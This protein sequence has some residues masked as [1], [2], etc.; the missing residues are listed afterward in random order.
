MSEG[1]TEKPASERGSVARERERLLE[2]E[3]ATR[4]EA[5]KARQETRAILESISDGFFALDRER[6]FVYVNREAERFWG[7]PRE[8]LLGKDIRRVFPQAVGTE[9]YR[10]IDRAAK[11]GVATEFEAAS[12]V[13]PGAWVGGRAYPSAEG[14]SVYFRDVSERKRAEEAL[15]ESEEFVRQLLRNFPN[16]S[17]N[18]FDRDLRYLL[19]EGRGLEEE[20]L[21]PEMLVGKTLEE[22]FPKESAD[23]VRPYYERA[24]AGEDVEFELP[25]GDRVYSIHAAPLRE[26]G[27]EVRTIIAV[28][29][30]V[31]GRKRAEDELRESRE[32]LG[33]SEEFHRFA[34]EAGRIGTWD[35]DLRTEECLISPKMADLMGFSPDQTTVPGAQWREAIVPDDRTSMASALAASIESGAPFDLE[36]RIALKDGTERW[37]YSR[38]GATRDASGKA[39]R[40]HGASIDVTERKRTEEELRESEERLRRAIGIETVGVI[41]FKADG[42]ITDSNDAFLRMSG[43]SRGD[44]EQGKVR[45]DVMTPP[46]WM[47]HS[48]KAIEEFEST[49]RTEPYEKEYVRKDGSRW[50]G[51]F[52]ATR[53]DD[54]E[55]VEF[56]IDITEGKRAEEAL[57]E[58]EERF[59]TLMEQSPLAIHVFAPDGTSLRY[60]EAWKELWDLEESSAS[61]NIFDEE[62]VRAAGLVPYLEKG[63]AGSEEVT[64]PLLYDPAPT[65][66]RG[67]P[68]WLRA[69][70]YPV[71]DRSGRVFE[72]ALMLEDVTERERAQEERER[73]LAREWKARAEA[74]ERKRISRELHDRVAHAMGVAH[75]SLELHEALKHSDPEAARAKMSLAKESTIEA[76]NLTRDLAQEL[77]GAEV[78]GSLSAALSGL[79][80]AAVPPGVERAVSVEGDEAI[81]PPYV[82]EQLFVILREGVRNA[83]SHSEAGRIDVGVRVC[84]EEVVGYVEDDGRGFAEEEGATRGGVRSMRERAGLVGGTFRSASGSGVG[85]AIR[86]TIPLKGGSDNGT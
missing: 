73:L 64:D 69:F 27:G 68:R 26:E 14:L 18:V 16:G 47:A 80:E 59:R 5:E 1:P 10:A 43:Y 12:S 29:Q 44:L 32:A 57:R 71:R 51:L 6:R 34:A 20:G 30:D 45:W 62:R 66:G 49:G 50:W 19:A 82:R 37:L 25:L 53:L 4:A 42:S 67:E 52:A 22:L 85:T 21:S 77:R 7:K 81:V 15:R 38:G 8:E 78:K 33:K 70:V 55:G 86:V 31:T 24:F 74:E 75:Q 39:L 9:G 23:F 65:R 11:E 63:A 46:E 60:N 35:L 56:I 17:V 61:P 54:E 40:V 36:F 41:I 2:R 13:V 79:I 76:M 83:V 72:V 58:S 48:L 3:R 84:S 28:A